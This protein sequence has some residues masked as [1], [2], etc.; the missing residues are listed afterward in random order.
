MAGSALLAVAFD[1]GTTYSGYAFS[2]RNDPLKVQTN[3]GWIAGSDQLIS[4]KTPTCVL[5]NSSGQF[6][7]FGFEAENNFATLAEDNKHH[8]W[9]LFRRFKM[10]LHSNENLSRSTTVEDINGKSMPAL[11]IFTMSIKFLKEHFTDALNKQKTGIEDK[12]IQYVITVPAIWNDNAK[13]FMREAAEKAGIEKAHLKL[14]FEPEAASIW[15][16]TITTDVQETWSKAGRQYM[17]IDLGGGTADISVHEK[18]IDNTLKELHKA[19]GG[20]WGGTV[21]DDNYLE[22]LT[23][24]FG[25]NTIQ[26]F[27][28]EQ[29]EDYFQLLREFEIKKRS[30]KP[31]SNGMI[32]FRL[33]ASLKELY[34]KGNKQ[35][36]EKK[37]AKLRLS[38]RVTF[39]GD[40]LR[41]EA[42]VIKKLFESPIDSMIE[43]V[44]QILAKPNMQKVETILLVGGFSECKLAQDLIQKELQHKRVIIPEETGL[45]VLKGAVRFGHFQNIVRSRIMTHTYGLSV[46]EDFV[47]R[48]HKNAKVKFI[49]GQKHAD[50]VFWIMIRAGE[51]V[52]IGKVISKGPFTPVAPDRSSVIVYCTEEMDPEYTT[53]IGCKYMG[54][55]VVDHANGRSEKDN[56]L[57]ISFIFGDTELFVK[58]VNI[59]TKEQFSSYMDCL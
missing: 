44:Q 4:L 29:M 10:I 5:L 21:V 37:L 34:Q 24:I 42:S 43:H 9:L 30:I 49:N 57:E 38:D 40:K 27:K 20:P 8:G 35:S 50:D 2:F 13:Q 36:L 53:D 17:V 16:Q 11:T 22:F 51:E 59:R 31:E 54:T 46:V 25:K 28:D 15:C 45:V 23:N 55:V 52:K 41:V 14:S 26:R 6:D 7:S 48:K 18:Q 39:T 32:T 33:S 56:Q 47:E 3:Q 58:T 12:D 19:S 1:F